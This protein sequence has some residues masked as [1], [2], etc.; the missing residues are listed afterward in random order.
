MSTLDP[1]PKDKSGMLFASCKAIEQCFGTMKRLFGLHRAQYF[2]VAK[3]HA[4]RL[5]G[6]R[7]S[8]PSQTQSR[9]L[10]LSPALRRDHRVVNT[11]GLNRIYE[12]SCLPLRPLQR[13]VLL[14]PIT[15]QRRGRSGSPC[16]MIPETVRAILAA[17][18]VHALRR[19]CLLW[20]SLAIERSNVSRKLLVHCTIATWP[21][22]QRVQCSRAFPYLIAFFGHGKYWIGWSPSPSHKTWGTA[23]DGQSGVAHPRRPRWSGH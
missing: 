22:I 14:L 6:Q 23:G 3:T 11:E 1:V 18:A 4:V 15:P 17:I 8:L 16:F 21:A 2:G 20:R 19:K 13:K 7:P 5:F 12:V 9:L 10:R